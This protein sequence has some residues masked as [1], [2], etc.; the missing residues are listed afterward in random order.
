MIIVGAGG[1]GR[2]IADIVKESGD[3]VYG[4]LDDNETK[5][6]RDYPILNKIENYCQYKEKYF[7]IAI[8]NNNLR[9]SLSE[10]LDGVKYYTAIHPRAYLGRNVIIGEGTCIMANAVVNSGATVGKHCILNTMS[11]TEHDNLIG[12]FVHVS[13]GAVLCGTVTVGDLTHIGANSVVKNNISICEN[14]IVGCGAC[15]VKNINRP[16]KYIGVPVTEYKPVP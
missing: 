9:K 8:G 14:V 11:V 7:I 5:T 15:V 13:P 12:N 6:S 1:H 2:V 3:K 16:G 4:F 10:M